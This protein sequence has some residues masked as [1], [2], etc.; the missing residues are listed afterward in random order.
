MEQRKN[1]GSECL[2]ATLGNKSRTMDKQHLLQEFYRGSVRALSRLISLVENDPSGSLDLLSNLNPS[3]KAAVVGIT[4]PPGS[5][6]STLINAM[7]NTLLG[8][9][10]RV[11]VVAVDPSSPFHGG[12]LL[13]DRIRMQSHFTHPDVYIRSLASRG[14]LGGLTGTS[15]EVVDVLKAFGFDYILIET[16]GVGQS[17]VEIASLADTTLVVLVPEAGDEI[18]AL[19]SGLMEIADLFIVNKS[20][21]EG[22]RELAIVLQ[23]MLHD[24]PPSAWQIPV[25]QTIATGNEQ[26]GEIFAQIRLHQEAVSGLKRPFLLASRAWQLIASDRMRQVNK[27]ELL[28]QVE[29]AAAHDDFNLYKFVKKYSG[30]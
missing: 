6:K 10:K 21:R 3:K 19:K 16:V 7:V 17:E 8:E 9:G 14:S 4:G 13:G 11:A 5:G 23:R 29:A 25:I 1:R 15:I 30:R 27:D 20:D 24:R 12:A 26:I 22:A 28:K 2:P 18:Q